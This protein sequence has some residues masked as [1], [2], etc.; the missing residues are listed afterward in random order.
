MIKKLLFAVLGA[1]CCN[2]SFAQ[3]DTSGGRY[4]DPIFPNITVSSNVVYGANN[5]YNGANQTLLMDIYQPT[6]DN[7]EARPLIILA[8]GGSFIG[9]TK[10]D[11]DIVEIAR[12]FAKMGYVTASIEY[13]VGFYP[14]DSINA[15]RAVLRAVQDMKAAVRFF[16]QDAAT[17][18]VYKIHPGYIYAGG[19]SAGAFM[20][21]HMEYMDREDEVTQ[22]ISASALNTLGGLEGSSGNPGYLTKVSAVINLCGAIGKKEWI[23]AGN[24]PMVSLHGPNDQ[25]VPFGSDR[26]YVAG[27]PIMVVHGSSSMHATA[28]SVNVANPFHIYYGAGHV[29]YLGTTQTA[30]AYMDTTV[31]FVR[32]FLRP[33]LKQQPLVPLVVGL[34]DRQQMQVKMYPNPASNQVFIESEN[35][36]N[37]QLEIY[38]ISG[39]LISSHFITKSARIPLAMQPGLYFV[40]LYE[41]GHLQKVEKLLVR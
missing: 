7:L 21:V 35:L 22:M 36:F 26:I 23:E 3:L 39:Q 2:Q 13:R 11:Q 10:T 20:A 8:H 34:D 30:V 32:D 9:G 38:N 31:N 5:K 37:G 40:R 29:P 27:F 25:T 18:N 24:V 14:I 6:G 4:H 17:N 41:N 16:R 19:S 33:L 12:R 15:I 28:S 1:L